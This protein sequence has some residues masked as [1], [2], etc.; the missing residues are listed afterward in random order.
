[1]SDEV[2]IIDLYYD[3]YPTL[4]DTCTLKSAKVLVCVYLFVNTYTQKHSCINSV[5]HNIWQK[6]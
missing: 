1:M 5:V 6:K 2:E 3:L 4:M